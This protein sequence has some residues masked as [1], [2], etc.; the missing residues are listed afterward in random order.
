MVCAKA[1]L[2]FS[3]IASLKSATAASKLRDTM[4]T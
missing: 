4:W 2:G 3:S 1:K